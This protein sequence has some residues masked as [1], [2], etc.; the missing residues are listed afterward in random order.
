MRLAVALVVAVGLIAAP[1][2][3]RAA[4]PAS[5]FGVMADGPIFAPT[6]DLGGE[7]ALMRA[8]GAGSTRVA[9]QW[10]T[11]EPQP[12]VLD[13]TSPDAVIAATAR[14]GLQVL[15]V[16]LGTP[17]WAAR[18]PS[19]PASPPKSPA[20]YANLLASLV[21][22]YGP[23]G[24]FWV[25]HPELPRMPLRQWQIWNEPD[26]GKYW[27][28][29]QWAPGYVSLLRAARAA[30]KAADPSATIVLAGLTNRSWEDLRR[31]YRAGGRRLFDVAAVHP[32][33]RRVSNVMK[34]VSLVRREM[35]R[36]GD[37]RKRLVLSEVSWSSGRG[38]STFNY[39]WEVTER[40]QA[41]RLAAALVRLAARRRADRIAAIYW[42][43]WL[44]PA[45]GGK[46]SF[47]YSGLRRLDAAGRPV[48]KPALTAFRVVARGL[49]RAGGSSA[50]GRRDVR[51]ARRCQRVAELRGPALR[52]QLVCQ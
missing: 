52:S 51:P 32:F 34:I 37:A 38:H 26:L 41:L 18:D 47:D 17:P 15:P 23:S 9:V 13:F 3:A 7:L 50:V 49:E 43:T 12:G 31:I 1:A 19:D 5:F 2:S 6:V 29:R 36:H 14:A 45:I 39:G 11:V 40:A 4:V 22:R 35:R 48:S 25:A 30:I 44:S 10:R 46:D 16:V 24:T 33:S 8:S 21:Q 27:S 42:Y 28:G 20:P